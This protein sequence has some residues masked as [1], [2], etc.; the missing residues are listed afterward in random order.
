MCQNTHGHLVILT[1]SKVPPDSF[2]GAQTVYVLMQLT[3]HGEHA[4]HQA[5]VSPGQHDIF[6]IGLLVAPGLPGGIDP[7]GEDEQVEDDDADEP[8]DVELCR[9]DA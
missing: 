5:D 9:H 2:K 1:R 4:Y 3:C 6:R 8:G 7:D